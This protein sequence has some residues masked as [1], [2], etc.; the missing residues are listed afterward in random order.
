M[1]IGALVKDYPYRIARLEPL[2][3]LDQGQDFQAE[4]EDLLLRLNYLVTYAPENMDYSPVLQSN[5][6][7]DALINLVART[8]P[9]K[10]AEHYDL[11]AMDT[12]RERARKI[13]AIIDDQIETMEL[14]KRVDPHSPDLMTYN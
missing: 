9:L 7:F 10:H 8:L 11:L 2:P 3:E 6:P 4:R 12:I 13:L 5:E 14:M 1:G